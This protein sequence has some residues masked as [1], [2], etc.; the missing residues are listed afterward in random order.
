MCSISQ[1]H[2]ASCCLWHQE[3]FRTF[4]KLFCWIITKRKTNSAVKMPTMKWKVNI[5]SP[6]CEQFVS[7]RSGIIKTFQ[8]N[9]NL[10][11]L[12][13]SITTTST[14]HLQYHCIS[15]TALQYTGSTALH[16]ITFLSSA[17]VNDTATLRLRKN[18][19]CLAFYNVKK[20]IFTI[21]G[22]LYD[23]ISNF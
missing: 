3:T 12:V 9:D 16:L 10:V 4:K 7:N 19:A 2:L 20:I 8:H 11:L 17:F 21:L 23:E 15:W 13:T 14:T 1:T 5:L 18:S 6:Q 22:T